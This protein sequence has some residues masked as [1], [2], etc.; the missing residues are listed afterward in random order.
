MQMLA[1]KPR[2]RREG[3]PVREGSVA[4]ARKEAGLSLAEVAKGRLSRTAI[5]LIEKGTSRPSLETLKHIAQQ[6]GKPLSF[7]L[8]GAKSRSP[9]M[10]MTQLLRAKNDLSEALAAGEA[11]RERSVQAKVCMVLGQVE[12]WC[13]NVAGADEQFA[14]A[15]QILE[16]LGK[17]VLLRDAHMTYAELLE[18]R[19]AIS[20][21]A[22]HWKL[23]AEIGKLASVMIDSNPR[24]AT[25]DGR[26]KTSDLSA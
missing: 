5:H 23:A 12:E 17:P 8:N 25:I 7:F 6:T 16:R 26:G 11:N 1:T 20:A 21:A 22:H 2:G 14:T 19:L 3:V 9:F 24:N 13:G 10:E 4:E 15:I 18:S